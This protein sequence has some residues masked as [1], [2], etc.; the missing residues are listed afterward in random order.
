MTISALVPLD[1]LAGYRFLQRTRDQQE[2]LI[3]QSALS[4][5]LEESFKER[6]GSIETPAQLVNDREL[7]EVSLAAF[8]LSSDIDSKFFIQKVLE[9][10]TTDTSAL[11]NKL[12]DQRYQDFSKAFGFGDRTIPRTQ[13]S[14]FADEILAEYRSSS[15]ETSVGEQDETLRIALNADRL[16]SDIASEDSSDRTKWLSVIGNEPLLQL[17]Q[18]ALGLPDSVAQLD[19]DRQIEIYDEKL[20]RQMGFEISDLVEDESRD[21]LIERFLLRSSINTA[22]TSSPGAMALTLLT[23]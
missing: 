17:V 13:L 1:G 16:L 22:D 15:F 10:G 23:S 4:Q 2:D 8:G 14:G 5:R 20:Q 11:A 19:L 6:I 21:A 18:G 7:L 3:S 9:E 12:A